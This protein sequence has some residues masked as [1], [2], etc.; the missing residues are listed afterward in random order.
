VKQNFHD[1]HN[2]EQEIVQEMIDKDPY[3][4][5]GVKNFGNQVGEEAKTESKVFVHKN[6]EVEHS[7][8]D[9]Q[10]III[11]EKIRD[12]QEDGFNN[13]N[14]NDQHLASI[15]CVEPDHQVDFYNLETVRKI[16]DFQFITTKWFLQLMFKFYLFGFMIPFIISLCKPSLLILNITYTMC[17]FTQ[18][19]FIMFELVQFKEQGLSYFTDLY[20]LV[21]TS[22]FAIFVLL[23][24]TKMLTQFDSDSIMEILMQGVLLY[25]CFYKVF[26][27]IRIYDSMAFILTLL[28]NI[29]YE[30]IPFALFILGLLLGFVKIYSLFHV[31]YDGNMIQPGLFN[32]L[33]EQVEDD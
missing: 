1:F 22:Q 6:V 7:L 31:G 20:N 10:K 4:T 9:F 17:L 12:V 33:G 32:G 5:W 14:F 11:G 23:Y 30:A 21:D 24:I 18:I 29:C 25:Q 3:M 19:F 26:Y 28:V 27:F 16:V 13:V 15:F 8:I 2:A